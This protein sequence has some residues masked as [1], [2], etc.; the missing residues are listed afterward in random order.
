FLPGR[1]RPQ[2]NCA[3][4]TAGGQGLAVGREGG[5]KEIY[6]FI[7]VAE[8]LSRGGVPQA[9]S[10]P[11]ADG[12]LPV[13]NSQHMTVWGKGKRCMVNGTALP[14]AAQLFAGAHVP[15]A[16]RI[17]PSAGDDSAIRG[18]GDRLA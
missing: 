6:V 11:G 8:F 5:R 3:I 9:D 13:D 15:K 14:E 12:P 7:P 2:A 4:V 10:R 17:F 1:D 18:K 16:N